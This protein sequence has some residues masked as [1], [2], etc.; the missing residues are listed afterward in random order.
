LAIVILGRL[1]VYSVAP[2]FLFITRAVQ[3]VGKSEKIFINRFV[4]IEIIVETYLIPRK[5]I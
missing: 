4:N 3:S 1:I 5:F 2:E